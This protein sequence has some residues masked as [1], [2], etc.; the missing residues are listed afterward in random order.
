MF[1]LTYVSSAMNPFTPRE[2]RGLLE[3]AN[4]NNRKL[5]VTGMLLYK[6]GNFMQVLE[7]DER[8][9][10]SVHERIARDPRHRGVTTLLQGETPGREFQNWSMGFK[11]LG[12]DVDNPEGYSEFLNVPLNSPQFFDSPGKAQ[13]LLLSFKKNM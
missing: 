7:G 11:D 6:D 4:H 2:L 5:D 12:A 8:V 1:S 3:I 9:V 10:R 13:R